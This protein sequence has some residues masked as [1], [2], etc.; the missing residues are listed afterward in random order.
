M[1]T[2]TNCYVPKATLPKRPDW[3]R[4]LPQP[5]VIPG[6]MT[7]ATLADVRTLLGHLPAEHR[8]KEIWRNV[9]RKLDEVA[10]GA[11]VVEV[12]ALLRTVLAMDGI[13]YRRNSDVRCRLVPAEHAAGFTVSASQSWQPKHFRSCDF[14]LSARQTDITQFLVAEA[15]QLAAQ[16]HV[17]APLK[18]PMPEVTQCVALSLVMRLNGEFTEPTTSIVN[19]RRIMVSLLALRNT[20]GNK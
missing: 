19:P 4:P 1:S 12:F 9:A 5:L 18:E 16:M 6:L 13:T 2:K 17:A 7:L 20:S 8:E 11:P 3:S 15:H 10:R 14:Y